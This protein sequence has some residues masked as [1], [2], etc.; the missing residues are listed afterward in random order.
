[1]AEKKTRDDFN[2]QQGV[3]T[4]PK[5]GILNVGC[6]KGREEE[7]SGTTPPGEGILRDIEV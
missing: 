4:L 2:I 7:G 5:K 1:M 3:A 6:D